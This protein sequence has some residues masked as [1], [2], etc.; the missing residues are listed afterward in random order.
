MDLN[1]VYSSDDNYCEYMGVSIKSLFSNNEEFRNITVYIL[2]NKISDLNKDRILRLAKEYKREIFFIEFS[3]IE[4]KAGTELSN[5]RSLSMYSRLFL[6]SILPNSIDKIIYMDC[7]SLVLSSLKQLWELDINNYLVAGV[8]DIISSY[9]KKSIGIYDEKYVNSGFLLINLK[10]WREEN[11][12][13]EM[14]QFIYRFGGNVPKHD[15]GVINGTMHDS[16]L[17]I[18]PKYNSITP[19][20]EM[21]YSK[22]IKIYNLKEYYSYNEISEAT[23]KPVFVHF[24]PSFSKRPWIIGSHHPLKDLYL[25]YKMDSPWKDTNLQKDKS[26]FHVK[27]LSLI[28]RYFPFFFL[29]LIVKIRD[30]YKRT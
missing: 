14:K 29:S 3:D 21:D 23:N 18:E 7:D 27:I 24:V 13:E 17:L 11:Q 9:N 2:D 19:F 22:L 10:R 1:I 20:F 12:E 16:M 15:Q 30:S 6:G 26:K 28:H 25:E 4:K 5:D 8:N